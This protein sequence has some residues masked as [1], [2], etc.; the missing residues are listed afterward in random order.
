M[1]A[2][3]GPL[4]IQK[5][6]LQSCLSCSYYMTL[7]HTTLVYIW[8]RMNKTVVCR[9]EVH[10][11]D[12]LGFPHVDHSQGG[13]IFTLVYLSSVVSPDWFDYDGGSP[14]TTGMPHKHQTQAVC[15]MCRGLC[16]TT[17][18]VASKGLLCGLGEQSEMCLLQEV[19]PSN[20]NTYKYT[21]TFA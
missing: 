18:G 15:D 8:E 14:V 2:K 20:K 3:P 9:K 19:Q 21:H 17:N 13:A 10:T 12:S 7:Y 16:T 1:V 5:I 11:R 4:W 6:D